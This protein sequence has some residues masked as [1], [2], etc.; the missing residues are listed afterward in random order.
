MTRRHHKQEPPPANA[1]LEAVIEE[2]LAPLR[3][4]VDR[5]EQRAL[6]AEA[7]LAKRDLNEV[8][9]TAGARLG[10]APRALKDFCARARDTFRLESGNLTAFDDDVPV[11]STMDPRQLMDIG[12]FTDELRATAPHL[13]RKQR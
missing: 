6:D 2:Q 4:E 5:R 13:F 11:F 1:E 7:K 8:L 10:I 12:E 9:S 3:A